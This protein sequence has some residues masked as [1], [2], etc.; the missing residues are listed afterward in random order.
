MSDTPLQFEMFPAR[1]DQVAGN[2]TPSSP[3]IAA[4]Q[5]A[6]KPRPEKPGKPRKAPEPEQPSA[7]SSVPAVKFL[8]VRAVA[9]RYSVSRATIWRWVHLREGFP[10]GRRL[11]ARCTRWCVAELDAFDARIAAEEQA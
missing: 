11:S 9:K 7:S 6:A 1:A 3:E 4:K 10:Q 8:P 2:Q 5:K